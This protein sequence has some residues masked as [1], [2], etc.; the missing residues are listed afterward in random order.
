MFTYLAV[1]QDE[2]P[3][4]VLTSRASLISKYKHNKLEITLPAEERATRQCMRSQLPGYI[5]AE[6][7]DIFDSRAE[8]QI[9]RILNE[10]GTGTD[11]ILFEEGISPVSWLPET[12]RPAP[13][14]PVIAP[15][16]SDLAD[17]ELNLPT[18]PIQTNYRQSY[19]ALPVE[20]QHE[21][22]APDY[23]KVIEHVHKQASK[24]GNRLHRRNDE[25]GNF[26]DLAADFAGLVLDHTIQDHNDCP[27]LFG[28]DVW[29]SKF[30]LGA[31][32]EL[33]VS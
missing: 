28:N 5:A 11:D 10:L 7:L 26:D 15:Q 18:G 32:G 17:D 20:I 2:H 22:D 12:R 6:L 27:N 1:M 31:A 16:P 30:R 9:Y 14:P 23:W 25:T 33:F 24:I 19:R 4:K 29:L 21:I 13:M 3:V 8:K